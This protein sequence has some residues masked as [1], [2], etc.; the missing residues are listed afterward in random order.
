MV[1]VLAGYLLSCNRVAIVDEFLRIIYKVR[2][3]DRNEILGE[4]NTMLEHDE[5]LYSSAHAN[6]TAHM[7]SKM[8]AVSNAIRNSGDIN[9]LLD[10]GDH[11]AFSRFFVW[12]QEENHIQLIQKEEGVQPTTVDMPIGEW[13]GVYDYL[14]ANEAEIDKTS[15]RKVFDAY[16]V[17]V[18]PAARDIYNARYYHHLQ[19]MLDG[20]AK[21]RFVLGETE[22]LKVEQVDLDYAKLMWRILLKYWDTMNAKDWSW[23]GDVNIL[24]TQEKKLYEIFLAKDRI[25]YKSM[26]E[27]LVENDISEDVLLALKQLR[28]IRLTEDTNYYVLA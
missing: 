10:Q 21:T 15:L 27:L 22:V 1:S 17:F 9:G 11:A 2:T 6:I 7:R 18:P 5:K 12:Y 8:L 23:G 4:L 20:L 16:R 3:E 26:K 25:L 19:C 28:V 13:L 14:V 24:T